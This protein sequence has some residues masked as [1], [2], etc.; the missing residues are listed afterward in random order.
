M[1]RSILPRYFILSVLLLLTLV[2]VY[3]FFEARR[4]QDELLRQTE[5]KGLALADAMEANIRSSVL[6][7]ALL[8]EQIGQRLLDNARLIDELLQYPPT[9]EKLLKEITA[10]NRLK[11][12]ELLDL[13]GQP[14]AAL[15]VPMRG[16]MQ[17]MMSRMPEHPPAEL[18]D[19]RRAMMTYMWGRRWRLP[20]EQPTA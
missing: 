13:K 19:Q 8:E 11:K 14:L 3:I 7:N 10:T 1:G 4:F 5:A 12:I 15:P 16:R 9:D 17:G 18:P 6:A 20:Q 2:S